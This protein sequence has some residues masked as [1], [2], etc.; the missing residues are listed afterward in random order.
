MFAGS[1][2]GVVDISMDNT[3]GSNAIKIGGEDG[4]ALIEF[5]RW[6]ESTLLDD[7][8]KLLWWASFL[9]SLGGMCAASIG[10]EALGAI[11][12]INGRATAEILVQRM[13]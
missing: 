1:G 8:E 13:Q 4:I 10:T 3:S 7:K 2:F 11:A 6:R 9:G 5:I 12:E